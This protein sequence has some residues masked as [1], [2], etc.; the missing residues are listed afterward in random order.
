MSDEKVTEVANIPKELRTVVVCQ[1]KEI[2]QLKQEIHQLK[3]ENIQQMVKIEKLMVNKTNLEYELEE[4]KSEIIDGENSL[5]EIAKKD[6]IIRG[7][8]EECEDRATIN[9]SLERELQDIKESEKEC[10]EHLKNML[11]DNEWIRQEATKQER[12]I[13][14]LKAKLYDLISGGE[15]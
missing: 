3:Q 7:L 8:E 11:E 9:G 6:Q 15:N 14:E 13:L 4:A 2:Q 12:L 10:R 5:A 1:E